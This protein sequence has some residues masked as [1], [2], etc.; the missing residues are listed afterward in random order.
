MPTIAEE[1]LSQNYNQNYNQNHTHVVYANNS[2]IILQ[3][4]FSNT[5]NTYTT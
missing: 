3:T 5:H 4:W 1:R 2:N